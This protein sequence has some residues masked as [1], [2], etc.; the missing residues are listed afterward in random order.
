MSNKVDPK[1]AYTKFNLFGVTGNAEEDA[2]VKAAMKQEQADHC[3]S[4][5]KNYPGQNQA[6]FCW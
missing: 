5:I 4:D 1:L 6:Q 3:R 2:Q